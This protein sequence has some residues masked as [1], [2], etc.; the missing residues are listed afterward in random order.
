MDTV[1][2]SIIDP[3]QFVNKANKNYEK[4]CFFEKNYET[5]KK[6]SLVKLEKLRNTDYL[7]LENF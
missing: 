6:R 2:S 3:F 5:A 4:G 7:K 1:P